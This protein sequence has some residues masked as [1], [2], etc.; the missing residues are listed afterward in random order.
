MKQ[1][2][3]I[4]IGAVALV[5]ISVGISS[6]LLK[7]APVEPAAAAAVAEEEPL[8]VFYQNLMPEFVV[9]YG[10]RGRKQYLMV[11]VAVATTDS[12]VLAVLETHMPEI[13]NDL[14]LLFSTIGDGEDLYTEEGKQALREDALAT[15][16]GVVEKHYEPDRI[17]E[18][19]FTRFVMQ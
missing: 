8:E 15:V 16:N 19:F 14:L 2:L 13:R 11:D 12:K 6:V 3:M 18:L 5:G 17:D 7:P 10:P 1:M 9:N 4:G